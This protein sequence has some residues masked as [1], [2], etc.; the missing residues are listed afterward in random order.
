MTSMAIEQFISDGARWAAVTRRDAAAD[1][2]F[3][4]SVST[5]GVYC[6]PSCAARLPKREHV[7][8][9]STRAE[10][11]K[12]GFRP[13]KRCRPDEAPRAERQ[14]E[15]IA[16]ACRLIE[17]SE[18]LPGLDALAEVAGLSRFY[19]HRIFKQITGLTPKAY[20]AAHRASRVREELTRSSTVTEAI[21]EAGFQSSGRFYAAS[22]QILG[23]TPSNF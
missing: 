16:K 17:E 13:C 20:A 23:M 14:A 10:A 7:Q 6:R 11:E 8:F 4:Y 18:E 15:A 3:Y 2:L 1:D 21:Y 5:T 19:F 22:S 9:Y 12:A